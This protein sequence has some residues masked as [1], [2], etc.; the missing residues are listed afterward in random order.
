MLPATSVLEKLK[1][2]PVL[3]DL[4]LDGLTTLTRLVSHLK[5]DILQPQPVCESNSAIA[6][7]ILPQPIT[8]FLGAVL[9]TS[10]DVIDDCWEILQDYVW[11]API[12]P[13]TSEDFRL[14]K[15]FGWPCG[16]S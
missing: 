16:L 5:R 7:A 6:P 15:R 10:T 8:N 14:F 1:V 4:T 11:E 12:T 13:L 3:Q 9:G 2:H